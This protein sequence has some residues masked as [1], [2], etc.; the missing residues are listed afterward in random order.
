MRTLTGFIALGALLLPIMLSVAQP[1]GTVFLKP[2]DKA[3]D[4]KLQASDGREYQLSQ[5]LGTKAVAL[6]WFPRAG[7]EGAKIQCAALQAAIAGIPADKVQVFGCSTAPL[8]VTVAFGQAGKY[9]FP[10]LADPDGA[11]ARA[12]GCLRLDGRSERWT[13]LIDAK[14]TLLAISKNTTAQTQGQDLARMLVDAGLMPASAIPPP[15]ATA[16]DRQVSLQVGALTR[17]C[18]VHVPA[19]R[20]G[21]GPMPLVITLHG[22]RGSGKGA[23]GMSG[24][25]AMAD[26]YG[27]VA[28]Y[29]DGI[30]ADRSWNGLFGKI[31]GGQGILADDVD[32]IAFLRALIGLLHT[33]C[34]TDPARV[35][36]CGHSAGAYMAYRTGVELS[37]LVAA[38]GIVNGSLGIKS[39]DGKPCGATIPAPVAPVSVIHIAGLKDGVVKFAGAQTPKNLFKSA[40]DCI[41]FFVEADQ[42]NATGKERKDD[43][44]G[45]TRTLYSG[46]KAGTEV[47]LVTVANCDHSWPTVAQGLSASQELWDFFSAHPKTKAPTPGAG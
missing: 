17:T 26:R 39:L 19:P 25:N 13:F 30:A 4:F 14:G 7:S 20:E 34:N 23:V 42:C 40:P 46:G 18:L 45:V 29:A 27:F 11:V 3:P 32:D 10:V 28:A 47:E 31:P 16:V 33:T 2:G 1:L 44:T 8:D 41:R 15:P 22:A 24:F 36:V 5:F 38:V 6:C 37:D 21:A 12:Y 43:A 9:S 35:F